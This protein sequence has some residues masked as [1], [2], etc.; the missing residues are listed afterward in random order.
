MKILPISDIH[1]KQRE[2]FKWILENISVDDYELITV[3]GDIAERWD[4]GFVYD[5]KKF[6]IKVDKPIILCA[7]NHDWWEDREF[8][9]IDGIHLLHE[10]TVEINGVKFYGSPNSVT[11]GNWNH[12]FSEN[13]LFDIWDRN[14]PDDIDVMVMHSP[15]YGVCDNCLQPIFGNDKDTHLGSKALL[16]IVKNKKPKYLITGHIHSCDREGNIGETKCFGVSCVDEEYIFGGFNP[17]P[18][19]L[20]LKT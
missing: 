7:G 5:W 20:E 18:K 10:S 2:I 12:M 8:D 11:F 19:V 16:E 17:Y 15:A 9:N 14:V 6:Q 13:E 4:T 1:G 3:S